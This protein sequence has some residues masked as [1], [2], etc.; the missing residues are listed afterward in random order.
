MD[1]VVAGT[2]AAV[3]MVES[4]AAAAVRRGHAGAVVFG[5]DQGKIAINRHQRTGARSRQARM[6]VEARPGRPDL[7]RQGQR[8]W[9]KAARGLPDPQQAGP[10]TQAAATAV[11]RNVMAALKAE[12]V[13]PTR[14][15]RR[16][17]V[18]DRER[19]SC[20]ARSCRRAAH[21]RP[22]HA[23]RAPDRD[24]HRRAAAHPRLGAVHAR[25]DAGAGGRHAG[26]RARR[27]AHRRA[28]RR[29]RRPLHAP[30]QHAPFATGETGPRG[31]PQAPRDRPR[32]PAKRALVAVLPSKEEFPAPSAWCRDHRESNGSSSMASVCGGCLSADGR[33][34]AAEGARGRHRHG[35]DQ[36]GN[37]FA[38][39][40]DILGDED[41][42]ATW[43]SRWPAPPAASPRCRWTSRSRASPRRSCRWRWR[44][45]RKRAPHPGQ[46]GR[47]HGRRQGRGEQFARACTR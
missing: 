1:L 22:R 25:R 35:P 5:H 36:E 27:A 43:T 33:R 9:P 13:G 38:V 18:R 7:H 45:P 47:G 20:A 31:Q 4:E 8:R 42:L 32:L 46:D 21:R 44:R 2:E 14:R 10:R 12:G 26:H 23:H 19:A 24:P 30:L 6:A 15:G 29:V 11:R 40:T 39:L 28:G 41:H 3:L 37:R 17:A 16:P 34:R